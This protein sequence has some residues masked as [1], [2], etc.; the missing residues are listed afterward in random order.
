MKTNP[1]YVAF[2]TQKGGAGKTTLTV[3]VASYL[4]YVKGCNVAV[5]DCDYPQHSIVGMR[6]RDLVLA[7]ED[8]HYKGMAYEQFTRLD[9]KA[10]HV[11]GS[12]PEEALADAD[13]LVPQGNYDFIFFDLP[14]TVNN[15]GVLSTL[16]N[17]DYI[18]APIAA[19][20][21]VM[22]STLDYLIALRDQVRA[23]GK[24]H[25]KRT[26]LLWNM[27]DGREKSELYDV[28]EAVIRELEFTTLQTFVPDSK[29][30]RKEQNTGHKALF[31]ST[32]F[33]ADKSLVK[34]SN[35]DALVDELLGILK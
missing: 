34:G 27:V 26:Y 21:V 2:A 3:L 20:R 24:T 19:D 16:L 35:M 5:I 11:I 4:H 22:E 18:I 15:K 31:R 13:Y 8:E 1:V 9:K 28:Y 12:S 10:W 6:E 14:G 29:R 32:L 7:T 33:P 23:V 25:I 30:F 17:M